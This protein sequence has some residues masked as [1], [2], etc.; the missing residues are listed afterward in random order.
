MWS[1]K[2][3]DC[4]HLFPLTSRASHCTRQ[5]VVIISKRKQDFTIRNMFI[6]NIHTFE[7]FPTRPHLYIQ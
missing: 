5:T 1:I 3:T 2:L 6:L 7:G 4:L